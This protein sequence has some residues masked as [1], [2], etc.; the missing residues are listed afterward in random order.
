[1]DIVSVMDTRS[2]YSSVDNTV[3]VANQYAEVRLPLQQY[4]KRST[5]FFCMKSLLEKKN[6]FILIT[7]NVFFDDL[8]RIILNFKKRNFASPRTH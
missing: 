6:P 1:M 5:Y 2:L 3:P 7:L 8:C 4:I